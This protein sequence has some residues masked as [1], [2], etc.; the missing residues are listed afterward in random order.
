MRPPLPSPLYPVIAVPRYKRD[1]LFIAVL[2]ISLEWIP[3]QYSS[4]G[5]IAI[6]NFPALS[7]P[8]GRRTVKVD[9]ASVYVMS[10]SWRNLAPRGRYIV[11][12]CTARNGGLL[13]YSTTLHLFDGGLA[14]WYI[15]TDAVAPLQFS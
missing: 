2:Y 9:C 8:R 11:H 15:G 6:F 10:I 7:A 13:E 1:I 14:V 4:I 3:L 5:N 12:N